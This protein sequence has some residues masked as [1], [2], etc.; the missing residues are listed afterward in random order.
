MDTLPARLSTVQ[1][2]GC[3]RTDHRA[4]KHLHWSTRWSSLLPSI[5]R[6]PYKIEKCGNGFVGN[7]TLNMFDQ[8]FTKKCRIWA[9]SQHVQTHQNILGKKKNC[10]FT[11]SD[12]QPDKLLWHSFWH[13]IWNKIL[14]INSGVLSDALSALLPDRY[15]DIYLAFF[16]AFYLAFT[17]TFYLDYLASFLAQSIWN[18]FWRSI[19]HVFWFWRAIWPSFWNLL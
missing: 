6:P 4:P 8:K 16:L 17:L 14:H 12:P 18:L 7:L 10:H 5:K 3:R 15:S 1:C 9:L 13:I 2:L 11:P 19:W